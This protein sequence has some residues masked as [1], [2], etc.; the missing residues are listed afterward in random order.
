[1]YI[2]VPPVYLVPSETEDC[3]GCLGIEVTDDCE[4]SS[5][6]GELGCSTGTVRALNH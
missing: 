1:M 2:C 5:G 6:C 3:V 4:P